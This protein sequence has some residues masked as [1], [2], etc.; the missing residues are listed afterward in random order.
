MS[1]RQMYR[2]SIAVS[3]RYTF[4]ADLGRP[5]EWA[6]PVEW[7]K[8]NI[9]PIEDGLRFEPDLD[10]GLFLVNDYKQIYFKNMPEFDLTDA[11]QG[12][13]DSIGITTPRVYYFFDGS[14]HWEKLREDWTRGG[15]GVKHYKV[16]VKRGEGIDGYL[17]DESFEG[18]PPTPILDLVDRF[19][20]EVNELA[21]V[22][23]ILENNDL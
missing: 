22:A 18:N 7:I 20:N 3:V 12:A 19:T 8:C 14:W 23:N 5:E 16:V 6:T 15:R 10:L 2:E 17:P 9:Q 13:I 11:P 21:Q 4:N 1:L